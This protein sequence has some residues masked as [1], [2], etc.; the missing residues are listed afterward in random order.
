MVA[1]R[2]A[3]IITSQ[4]QPVVTSALRHGD[5]PRCTS[6]AVVESAAGEFAAEQVVNCAGLYSD[7]VTRLSGVKPSALIL[8]FRGEFYTLKP[9]AHRL[10]RGLIYPIG[11]PNF[12]FLGVHFTKIVHGGFE[13][14]PNAVLAFAR[15]GYRNTDDQ[16]PRHCRMGRLHRLVADGRQALADG[17]RRNVAQLQQAA[18]VRALQR[19]IPEIKERRA[20]LG[21][22]RRASPS[23]VAARATSSTTGSST[24]RIASSTS[25]TH[26]RPPPP[27][28]STS[29]GSSSN[30]WPR[31]SREL[32][33]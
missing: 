4:G 17:S 25:R 3:E 12:P 16:S 24:R 28:P 8:P 26:P 7:R 19:L 22:G 20:R 31:D 5:S 9:E 21:A 18:F 30:A 23:R 33:C 10:V 27:P 1:R 15:E 13:C 29:A 2:L 32:R 6:Q 11:D 14:G